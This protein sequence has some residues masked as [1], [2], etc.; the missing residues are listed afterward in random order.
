MS[1]TIYQSMCLQLTTQEQCPSSISLCIFNWPCKSNVPPLSVYASSTDHARA[2]SPLYQSMR[3][4]L[5]MQ[6]Q[7]P[8]SINLCLQLTMQE[9][10]PPLSIYVSIDH[11][12][13]M[14]PLY[15]SMCQLTMQEQCP[16]SISLCVNWP[17]KSNVPLYLS[18]YVSSTDHARAMS[19][20]ISLCA[21]NMGSS[22]WIWARFDWLIDCFKSS[23]P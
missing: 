8:P 11:A 20:S 13:A 19:P 15:Q 17:R 4:Q 5:T 16:P 12:R 7:C 6:E 1:P 3:L 14:S 22:N 21:L 23:K 18:V 10:C 9:Q 2:M